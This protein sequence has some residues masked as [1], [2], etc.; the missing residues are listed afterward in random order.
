MQLVHEIH[1]R[2]VPWTVDCEF[3]NVKG[4]HAIVFIVTIRDVKTGDIILSTSVDYDRM[5][6]TDLERQ[7][8]THQETLSRRASRLCS[9]GYF[10]KWYNAFVTN[11]MSLPAIGEAMR[12]AGFSPSTHRIISWW[13]PVDCSFLSRALHGSNALIDKT[14]MSVL[15]VRDGQSAVMQPYDLARI[16]KLCTNLTSVACGWTYR[17]F[18]QKTLD[19]HHPDQDTLAT[20]EIYW[21]F[22]RETERWVLEGRE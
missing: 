5:E 1:R 14:P 21:H 9:V 20:S 22:I 8:T 17:S 7:L 11:G 12:T 13:T 18:F 4:A 6:L 2:F 3:A 10:A 16:I 19:F 15:D